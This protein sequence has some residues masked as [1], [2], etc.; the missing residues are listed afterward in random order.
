[1]FDIISANIGTSNNQREIRILATVWLKMQVFRDDALCRLLPS[2]SRVK[3]C[4]V[5]ALP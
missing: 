4:Q 3:Q 2:S 5:T 1:M